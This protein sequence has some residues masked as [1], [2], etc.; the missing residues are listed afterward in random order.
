ML[1]TQL[2]AQTL[3]LT[4]GCRF[5]SKVGQIGSKMDKSRTFSDH[6]SVHFGSGFV[7]FR[8][9]RAHF[10]ANPDTRNRHYVCVNWF[11]EYQ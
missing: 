10:G 4:Q 8:V 6:M 5:G 9:N 7:P 2:H 11:I 1:L 3:T